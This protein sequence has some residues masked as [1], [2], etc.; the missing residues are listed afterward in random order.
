VALAEGS[1]FGYARLV[2]KDGEAIGRPEMG[3]PT[4]GTSWSDT[5][6]NPFRI[7]EGQAP[8]ADN[9]V[10]IDR[11]SAREGD[12]RVGDTT[13]VLVQA[14]PQQ[15][16]IAG[17]ARYG[18]V[19]SPGGT[20][21]TMFKASVAQRLLAEPGKFD[22]IGV[23]GD[24]GVSQADL[25]ARVQAALPAGTEAVTGAQITKES[26]D[27]LRKAFTFFNTFML[28]FAVI[29]LL[30]G[31]FMIF[32]TFSITVAQRTRENGLLRALGASRRQVLSSVLWEA[33]AVGA[34]AS[35]VGLVAGFAVA[36]GLQSL[37][38]VMGFEIETSGLVF[39]TRTVVVAVVAGMAVTILAAVSPA[40]KAA[41]IPP[42]AAMHADVAGSTGY[43]SKER[44]IV[45]LL[46]IGTGVGLM[47]FGLFGNPSNALAI[48]G[49]GVLAVFFGVSAIGRTI[50]LPLSRV[51]G[52]P[53][54]RLRGT[55][56]ALAQENA[57]R[58][59]KRTAA[60]ASA[61]MI[62]VGLVGF[63]TILAASMKVSINAAIDRSVAGDLVVTSGTGTF[64]GVDA[65]FAKR[66]R[67]LPEVSAAS[68]VRI[69]MAKVE[70]SVKRVGAIDTAG[71]FEIIDT[72]PLQG[73]PQDL[74][75]GTIAVH[76]EEAKADGLALGD[77]VKVLF[78]DSGEQTL[79]VAMIFGEDQPLAAKYLMGMETYEANVAD[80]YD[81]QVYVKKAPGVTTA[82]ALAAVK[83]V[84]TAYPGIK[85]FDQEGFKAEQSRMINTILGFVYVLLALSVVIAL[86]GIGNTLALAIFERTRELG[87]LRAVGM[88]RAQLRQTIRWE[89]VLIALQGTI[90]GLVI[91]VFFGWALVAG[92]EDQGIEKFAIPVP[93]LVAVAV[94]AALAGVLA[95]ISPSRRAARLNVLEAIAAQ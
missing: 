27:E 77:Q 67:G 23:V 40:R 43:G 83:E 13:T 70:D 28:V 22:T 73:R 95:A 75:L 41:K 21:W 54:P 9:E 80:R 33:V 55:A 69:G 57:M 86:L 94:L 87:L 39:T 85:V 5:E 74:G 45:S 78:K 65:G 61:L 30:V 92:L 90:L 49:V 38:S 91:G 6:L 31:G 25:A 93:N 7:Y 53:L 50:S 76:E 8:R 19:D 46:L 56:G 12:L 35:L 16:R 17:I 88:T 60:S 42:I 52:A 63:I 51:L 36:T 3:P 14:G 59:P 71:G 11:Y 24:P 34:L 37:L 4:L 20:T 72:K 79:R 10:V 62:G 81:A 64:G 82:A 84:A 89:S 44:V 15:V 58:N 2:G 47:F 26:Q 1:I 29:A 48:L 18:S 32:N 68:G 66:L